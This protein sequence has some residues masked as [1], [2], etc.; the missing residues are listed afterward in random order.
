MVGLVCIAV[1][2]AC[3]ETLV[4]LSVL[5]QKPQS[6]LEPNQEQMDAQAARRRGVCYF[7]C[8]IF[9]PGVR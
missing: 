1:P 4:C 6:I 8:D 5:K 7:V 2:C 9:V 3:A